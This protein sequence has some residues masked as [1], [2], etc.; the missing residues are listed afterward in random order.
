[1]VTELGTPP[2]AETAPNS[3]SGS[4]QARYLILIC[5][6]AAACLLVWFG[7]AMWACWFRRLRR[8]A[9]RFASRKSVTAGTETDSRW[10][11]DEKDH[12]LF[13][14][15]GFHNQTVRQRKNDA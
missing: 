9:E 14:E 10:D 6:I 4:S 15:K 11:V 3:T 12:T 13:E 1:M 5:L 8:N 7:I 2:P